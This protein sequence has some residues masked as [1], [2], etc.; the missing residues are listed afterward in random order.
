MKTKTLM[1][2][3][4]LYF[5]I[6]SFWHFNSRFVLRQLFDKMIDSTLFDEVEGQI[7]SKKGLLWSLP[8]LNIISSSSSFP[9][10]LA[11]ARSVVGLWIVSFD[12]QV[13]NVQTLAYSVLLPTYL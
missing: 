4:K 2:P 3:E 10:P 8:K 9:F 12:S 7:I 13:C 11:C 5:R 6:S 1:F